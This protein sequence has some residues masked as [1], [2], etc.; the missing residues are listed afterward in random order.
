[1]DIVGTFREIN[2][3]IAILNQRIATLEEDIKNMRMTSN[4]VDDYDSHCMGLLARNP[5]KKEKRRI[6]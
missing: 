4:T 2:N 3:K 1:M 5:N 6:Q